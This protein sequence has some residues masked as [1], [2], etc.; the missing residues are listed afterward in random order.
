M[1]SMHTASFLKTDFT[2]RT[3]AETGKFKIIYLN[4]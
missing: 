1:K 4:L 2:E 3:A